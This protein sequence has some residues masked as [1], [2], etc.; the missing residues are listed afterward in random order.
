MG[1]TKILNLIQCK[2]GHV[3]IET[4]MMGAF[5]IGLGTVSTIKFIDS[6]KNVSNSSIEKCNS[7]S[8]FKADSKTSGE[9]PIK[10]NKANDNYANAINTPGSEYVLYNDLINNSPMPDTPRFD[11]R[12][13]IGT[14]LPETIEISASSDKPLYIS[15][16]GIKEYTKTIHAKI[17]DSK[18][19]DEENNEIGVVYKDKDIYKAT[20]NKTSNF[21]YD[22]INTIPDNMAIYGK[23]NLNKKLDYI[24]TPA[25]LKNKFNEIV[26]NPE[27]IWLFDKSSIEDSSNRTNLYLGFKMVN[28]KFTIPASQTQPILIKDTLYTSP[29]E[30]YSSKGKVYLKNDKIEIGEINDEGFAVVTLSTNTSRRNMKLNNFLFKCDLDIFNE[31]SHMYRLNMKYHRVTGHMNVY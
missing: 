29:I 6:G 25:T 19:Y 28:D 9:N 26:K 27:S 4:L 30:T 11:I 16:N 24:G 18:V 20:L 13:V 21:V 31:N 1:K 17:K 12:Y 22:N 3:T 14:K 5:I 2:K 10:E 23:N 15:S 7:I 8:F